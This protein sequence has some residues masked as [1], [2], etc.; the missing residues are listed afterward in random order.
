[1]ISTRAPRPP[2]LSSPSSNPTI[3]VYSK[4][5]SAEGRPAA[6]TTWGIQ[7]PR[8][9]SGWPHPWNGHPRSGAAK[10]DPANRDNDSSS[11]PASGAPRPSRFDVP[12][13]LRLSPKPASVVQNRTTTSIH[14]LV[15][16][17]EITYQ[18][19]SR[20]RRGSLAMRI[21]FSAPAAVDKADDHFETRRQ[22]IDLFDVQV[23][24][25][26]EDDEKIVDVACAPGEGRVSTASGSTGDEGSL[27]AR[28]RRA[29]PLPGGGGTTRNSPPAAVAT[30][31]LITHPAGV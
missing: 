13:K 6:R 22:T 15:S 18:T 24:M 27:T 30:S 8:W 9:C 31:R 3:I 23:T 11:F 4:I 10:V 5:G 19:R 26:I 21:E 1:M 2:H 16:P 14:R 28:H 17:P 29:G 12:G 20:A 7:A 25:H